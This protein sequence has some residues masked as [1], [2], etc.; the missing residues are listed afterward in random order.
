ML[1]QHDYVLR[2]DSRS[3]LGNYHLLQPLKRGGFATVY[4]AEHTYL[5]T[6]VAIKVLN[7]E[8]A[9]EALIQKFLVEAR[10]HAGLR[11]PHIA[12]VLDFGVCDQ[13][14]F[15]VMDYAPHKTLY[16]YFPYGSANSL[17]T[18]LP[19]V[20]QAATALKYLHSR[21]LVHCDVKPQNILLGPNNEAWLSDFGI[22]IATQPWHT[23]KLQNAVGTAVYAAP[24]QI[25][26]MPK[27]FSDQYSL[28]VL[29]Y[30][31]L[32]GHYPF[33]GTSSQICTHHLYSSPPPMREKLSTIDSSTER[34]VLKALAKDP[35][36]RF[37]DVIEFAHALQQSI[38][39]SRRITDSLSLSA[40]YSFQTPQALYSPVT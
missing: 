40:V 35:Y 21:G 28:A 26:G 9:N 24:E 8:R 20:E 12:R 13:L 3:Q 7:S 30:T 25:E 2:S 4:L 18:I 32:T 19:F 34:V 29:V 23:H 33:V 6:R 17:N 5:S 11:H 14:P 39:T 37:S 1:I 31:W 27:T 15:M 22:A 38:T 16:E 36:Q 10:I